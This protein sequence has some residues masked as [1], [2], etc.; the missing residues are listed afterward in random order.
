MDA[1]SG[2]AYAM[3]KVW[4]AVGGLFGAGA[5][6]AFWQPKALE[7]YSKYTKG[8]I[9]GGLG[10][11]A[12]VMFGALIA[13]QLG[14]D[15][16][17][18]DVG[19]AIGTVVGLSILGIVGFAANYFK[20]RES[21]DLVEVAQEAKAIAQGSNKPARKTTRKPAVKRAVKRVIK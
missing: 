16:Q 3:S 11:G 10:A 4:Y 8:L 20:K 17:S 18:A 14:L 21:M 12:P 2:A 15:P 7:E 9:I 6:G 19:M 5:I 1:T 13:A